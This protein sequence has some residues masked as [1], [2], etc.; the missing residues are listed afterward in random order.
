M[1]LARRNQNYWLPS[2]FNDF[3]ENEWVG[4]PNTTA[5]AINV[6]ES[7]DAYTVEVAA[8]GMT[9]S[10]FN[11]SIDADNN[12]VIA[13]EKK[14][15]HKEE[16]R[17]TRYL[18]REFSYAKFQQTMILPDDVDKDRISARGEDGVLMIGLPKVSHEE[19]R[20]SGRTIEI[21]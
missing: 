13:M 6:K 4:R 14:D 11:V 16:N 7:K 2:I 15:E 8:P 20:R 9:K 10:D 21:G 5:P 3:F 1:T 18:R 12:L 19:V 17:E